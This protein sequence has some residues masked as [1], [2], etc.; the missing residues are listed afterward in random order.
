MPVV[1]SDQC[2]LHDPQAEIFVGVPTPATEVAARAGAILETLRQAVAPVVEPE[3]HPD[4]ALHAVHDADL[5]AYLE[6]AWET[7]VAAGL[8]ATPARIGSFPTSS[9]TADQALSSAGRR[10]FV[11]CPVT[12][13]TTR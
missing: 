7:W 8:P 4:A 12:S 2:R 3:P 10:Q 1:W 11:P 9:P 13:P 6:S 5:L